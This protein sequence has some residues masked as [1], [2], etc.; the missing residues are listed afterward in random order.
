M[1]YSALTLSFVLAR[2]VSIQTRKSWRAQYSKYGKGA[3]FWLAPC[4]RAAWSGSLCAR[5]RSS[6]RFYDY[7]TPEPRARAV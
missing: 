2:L 4:A 6:S 1:Y 5:A 7:V 3:A